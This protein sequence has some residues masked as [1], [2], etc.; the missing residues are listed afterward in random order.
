MIQ[1]IVLACQTF[2]FRATIWWLWDVSL[3]GP[4]CI[5][6]IDIRFQSTLTILLFSATSLVVLNPFLLDTHILA[7]QQHTKFS[8]DSL[9]VLPLFGR[10]P[11][12][13]SFLDPCLP[14]AL[15]VYCIWVAFAQ[16]F[17][18][19]ERAHG[20]AKIRKLSPPPFD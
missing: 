9:D 18:A 3:A 4:P 13:T 7:S 5:S 19:C 14:S 16:F 8:T 1:A 10:T 17:C 11:V 20:I 15:L 12:H 2:L 6:A